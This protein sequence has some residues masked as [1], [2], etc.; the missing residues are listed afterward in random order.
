MLTGLSQKNARQMENDGASGFLE[1]SDAMLG[2]GTDSLLAKAKPG[3][4]SLY[5]SAKPGCGRMANSPKS[6]SRKELKSNY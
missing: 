3:L 6:A 1:K 5:H 4:L 2:Q